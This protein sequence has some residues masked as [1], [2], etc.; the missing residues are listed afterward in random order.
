MFQPEISRELGISRVTM[1]EHLAELEEDGLIYRNSVFF[2]TYR[3]GMGPRP[4]LWSIDDKY[5]IAIGV[6]ISE[7][8]AEITAINL[9][10][11]PLKCEMFRAE[12][13]NSGEYWGKIADKVKEF[14]ASLEIDDAD[15]KILGICFAIQGIT[16]EDGAKITYGELLKCTGLKIDVFTEKLNYTCRFVNTTSCAALC[17]LWLNPKLKS[18]F[19]FS[20]SEHLNGAFVMADD[21]LQAAKVCQ[22]MFEHIPAC[23]KRRTRSVRAVAKL[24]E[25]SWEIDCVIAPRLR[26]KI[27]SRRTSCAVFHEGR[28]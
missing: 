22:S 1:T 23:E 11:L 9:Y 28:Y 15:K 13:E 12:Y 5:R 24:S 27:Y 4:L 8:T 19:Y 20:M 3:D 18:L 25:S 7:H 21:I 16:S 2:Y 10:G 6:E 26:H 14:I 17:E